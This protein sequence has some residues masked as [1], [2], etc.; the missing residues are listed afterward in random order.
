MRVVGHDRRNKTSNRNQDILCEKE[1]NKVMVFN[2]TKR[3]DGLRTKQ[4][5]TK[6]QMKSARKR[7]E[8]KTVATII[9]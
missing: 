4:S 9:A 3:E 7:R 1:I 2:K 6:R 5:H 8:N